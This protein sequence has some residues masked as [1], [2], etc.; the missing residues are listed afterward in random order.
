[1][2]LQG[3]REEVREYVIEKRSLS[4]QLRPRESVTEDGRR[5]GG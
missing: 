4:G 3:L 1:M 2:G 5:N